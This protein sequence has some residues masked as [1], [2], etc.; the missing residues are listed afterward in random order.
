[1]KRLSISVLLIALT[2]ALFAQNWVDITNSAIQ[3]PS[4]DGSTYGWTVSFDDNAAENKGYQNAYYQNGDSY[5]YQ[6]F[7]AWVNNDKNSQYW[8]G[9]SNLGDGAISQ[10]L[11]NLTSGKLRLEADIIAV[12]QN[13]G[14]N[15]VSGVYLFISDGVQEATTEVATDNGKPQHFSVEFNNTKSSVT[16]GLRTESTNANWIAIDN[17]K[18][19]WYGTEVL[20][21]KIS[22]STSSLSLNLTNLQ[23]LEYHFEPSNTTN[24]SVDVTIDDWSIA[25]CTVYE[26]DKYIYVLG[27]AGGSTNITITSIANPNVKAVIPITVSEPATGI[28]LNKTYV[29]MRVDDTMTLTSSILPSNSTDS[30]AVTWNSSNT[31]VA[32]VNATTGVV[33]AKKAGTAII[34]ATLKAN[35][36]LTAT[37]DISVTDGPAQEWLDMTNE[38]V[39]NPSFDNSTNGWVVNYNG[40]TA[41]NYGFQSAKYENGDVVI[42]QFVEAWRPQESY[43]RNPLGNGSIYQVLDGLPAGHYKLE[44]DIIAKS[45]KYDESTPVTGVL[46]FMSDNNNES[47]EA[48]STSTVGP[49]HFSVEFDYLA[50]SLMIGIRTESTTANWL[51]MDNVKLSL[52]GTEV[53]ATQVTLNQTSAMLSQGEQLQLEATLL[54]AN[55]TFKGI[56]FSSSNE[57]CATVDQNGLVKALKPGMST[58]TAFATHDESVKATCLVTVEANPATADAVIINEVQPANLDMFVDPSSNYGGWI[59]LY[60]KTSKSASLDGLYIS[61]DP[62]NLKKFALNSSVHGSVPANGYLVLWFDHY[63]WWA[64]KMID[65]KLDCDGASIYI[66]NEAGDILAECDYDPAISRTSYARISDGASEWGFT[67]QPTP[68][69]SNN[70]SAFAD[71]RLETPEIDTDGCLFTGTINVK[72]SN[73]PSGASLIYTLD[74]STPTLKNG[75]TSAN[76]SFSFNKTTVLRVRFFQEGY[77]S[78]PVVTRSYIYKDKDYTLPVLSLV[79]DN[80]HLYGDQLGIFVEGSN[81][82]PGNG[83][84]YPCNWNMDWDRPANI[85]YFTENGQPG[86]NQEVSIEASGGW[87]RAWYPHSFNIK[88]N[89][90]YEG[91]N[92]MN[93]P[94][95]QE[96]P[97]LRHKGLKVRNGGNNVQDNG[98]GRTKDATLQ[99]IISTSGLYAETQSYQPVH[100]FHNGKY[101]GV[102]NLREPNSKHYGYANYAIDTDEQDQWKMSPDSGYVQQEGTKEI[103]NEWYTLAK[104]SYEGL[105]YERIKE[106]VDIEEYINYMAIEIYLAGHDW[107]KN[108]IKAFRDNVNAGSNSRFRFVLFDLDAAFS[109]SSAD[110]NW[111]TSTQY[112]TYD[113]LYGDQVIAKYG[114]RIYGE[115]E[116]VTIFL[117]MLQNES[118]KK[119]FIDQFCLVAGSVFEPTRSTAIINEIRDYVNP[120]MSLE[121]RSTNNTASHLTSNLSSSRQTNS[122]SNLRNF[123]GLNSPLQVTLGTNIEEARILVNDLT[124]P[125]NK[126]SGKLFTPIT[127]KASAPAGYQFMGW[128]S[129]KGTS[130]TTTLFGRGSNWSYYDQGSLDGT[131]WS[132]KNYSG[133]WNSG[134]APLGY[135]TSDA[136]N[137]RGYQTNLN[138]GGNANNKYPTYYFRKKV[139]LSA[140]PKAEETMTL[141][142]TADDG[143]IIYVNGTEAG[144]YLMPSG[145]VT[146][147]SYAATYAH[148]NPDAGQMTLDPTLFQKGENIIAVEVHNNDSKSTDIYWDAALLYTKSSTDGYA[149]TDETFTIPESVNNVKYTA[150]YEKLNDSA[151]DA[152]DAHPVKINEVSA[153]N[154]IYINDLNKKGDWVELYNTTDEPYDINGMFFSDYLG[155]PEKYQIIDDGSASTVIPAHGHLIIWCDEP[156]AS[157]QLTQLHAP[158]KLSNAKDS[159][160]KGTSVILTAADKS[161]ADTLTYCVHTGFQTVGLFPDGSSNLY[162]M[163]RPTIGKSNVVTTTALAYDEPKI[164]P[165]PIVGIQETRTE[166]GLELNYKS[167]ALTL[168]GANYARVDIY[169][170]AGR[171]RMTMRLKADTPRSLSSLPQGVYIATATTDDDQCSLKFNVQ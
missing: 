149:S 107:P 12:D 19:Y 101:I 146:F 65:L 118:F 31:T 165:Q 15:P 156:G 166:E 70:T 13:L 44:A 2:T 128:Q 145:S 142:W 25:E 97:Y 84:S 24:Q 69:A 109:A 14:N 35:T 78:S 152:W 56:S 103:F 117:N 112:W 94:F 100:L 38:Y 137:A 16:I 45:Q 42:N 7:E 81:G 151:D 102:E 57:K 67:D 55:A 27:K 72:V 54:P 59:E 11:S 169:D 63:S 144:R 43:Y 71:I 130:T 148:D 162:V 138:Y 160:K 91:M 41:Q 125:T 136:S 76:G 77:L 86:F 26:S 32:S 3:S 123:L 120:A 68:G 88:A 131:S 133:S 22:T 111:F 80:E 99:R 150:V 20:P 10:T 108:N 134:N 39:E 104:T 89:K 98:A 28:K 18:L 73:L 53:K 47:T 8:P 4:F 154:D 6:F 132:A 5:V 50:G 83:K 157:S 17:V 34:T 46:L 140:A 49:Q 90:I 153:S 52:Y 62:D 92:R 93:Y 139:N 66:S 126:F 116:F 115:I 119:Q 147:S 30:P 9:K 58:I 40:S 143:F 141:D 171:L 21:T 61:D 105:S 122:A 158:F 114:E 110:F 37:C 51:A 129:D 167:G 96:K 95:F 106:I 29:A 168:I 75:L 121:G 82:R 170:T 36:S 60:N 159:D 161:W 135:F 64:P 87:S 85:E 113:R 33:T 127:L 48:V 79:S 124:V 163:D 164:E 23:Y 155:N 74:G 1:M